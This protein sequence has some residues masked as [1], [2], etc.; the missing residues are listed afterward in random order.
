MATA[1]PIAANPPAGT[2]VRHRPGTTA[3][4]AAVL[5]AASATGARLAITGH[6]AHAGIGR[7]AGDAG[8][9]DLSGL[10]GVL[11]HE[12]EELVLSARA[13]TPVAE[14]TALLA[15]RGQHLACEVP[16]FSAL[17]GTPPGRGT[18]GGLVATN[19]CGPRRLSAGS[20]RDA[21]L[22]VEAVT[23]AGEIFRAGG[24][25][26]KNVTGFD[27]PRLLAGSWGSLAV[28]TEITLKVTPAPESDL[29][30]VFAGLDDT[31]ASALMTEAIG[32]GV[33]V[34]AAAHLP[35]AAAARVDASPAGSAAITLLRLEGIAVSVAAR[36]ERLI[37]QLS[38]YGAP[39][40][41]IAPA[42]AALWQAVR[43]ATPFSADRNRPVW[44][45][46]VAPTEGAALAAAIA[47]AHPGSEAFLDWAG[48]LVWLMLPADSPDA[49][50]E[51]V[52][53]AVSAAGGGHAT[54]IRAEDDIRARAAVFQPRAAGVAALEARVKDR[55]DPARIL[56]PGRLVTFA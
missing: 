45:V 29:T 8:I 15:S 32:F 21:V 9:L 14:I 18:L 7:P 40:R 6:G 44:R 25:V 55:F 52:R 1:E 49:G 50:A 42:S 51:A 41:V 10:S 16:D 22:G 39:A 27:L 33:D 19:L 4:V 17:L 53:A 37:R 38:A 20:I 23:G 43:D 46:S 56:E 12:P 35:A 24:R 31:R 3:E 34:A 11:L 26:V 36:A 2:P 54:L 5:A 47:A 48:G 13:G 28:M 30:L